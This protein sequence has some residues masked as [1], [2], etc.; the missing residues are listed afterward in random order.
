MIRGRETYNVEIKGLYKRRY[1]IK[2]KN[3]ETDRERERE[4]GVET[5]NVERED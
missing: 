4:R 5:Y 2:K 3:R 1:I